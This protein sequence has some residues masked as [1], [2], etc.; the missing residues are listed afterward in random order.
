MLRRAATVFAAGGLVAGAVIAG[1]AVSSGAATQA[2]SG[3]NRN[4]VSVKSSAVR[5]ALHAAARHAT[6]PSVPAGSAGPIAKHDGVTISENGITRTNGPRPKS[7]GQVPSAANTAITGASGVAAST[8]GLDLYDQRTANNGNQFTEVPPDQGLCTGN[9]FVIEIVNSVIQ[10]FDASTLQRL[11]GVTDTN[12][13]LGYP[14]E[15][16][17][18]TGVYGPEPTDPSC[19]YAE[20]HFV[21]VVLTIEVRPSSGNLTGK[22]HLDFA[23]STTNDPRGGWNVYQLPV[24]DDGTQGTPSHPDCPCLGDYPHIGQDA[25]GVFVTTNEYPFPGGGP[26]LF[27]NNYNGAQLY[28]ISKAALISGASSVPVLHFEDLQA[29]G[30]PG[31]TMWP[32]QANPGRYA[33]AHNGTEYFAETTTAEEALGQGVAYN[34][35]LWSLTNTA[36]LN[37]SSPS[38]TLH[39]WSLPSKKYVQPP[40]SNQKPGN[41]PLG[42]CVATAPCAHDFLGMA[43][44]FGALRPGGVDSLDGRMQQT[45]YDNGK[46]WGEFGAAVSVNSRIRAG[47]EWLVID[48]ATPSIAAQGLIGNASNNL[49]MPSIA[50]LPGGNGVMSLTAVGDTMDPSSAF[51]RINA[52]GP[53][54]AVNV[55][56]WGASPTDDF[57]EYNAFDCANTS[58]PLATPRW[59]DY[60]AVVPVGNQLLVANEDIESSCTLAQWEADA[61]CNATRAPLGNWSTHISRVSP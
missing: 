33:T 40:Q 58:P 1:P 28:A 7:P 47:A 59:G 50:V 38:P 9:G 43:S 34:I 23:V 25:N 51:V 56:K 22:Y 57:C 4:A 44:D 39:A 36:S 18:T 32:A 8:Q 24:Q 29:G 26:G 14:P 17:R 37:S 60:G 21:V 41:T 10:V 16:N 31:F 52:S 48:T 6:F 42:D 13:F 20:G 19:I 3:A 49:V 15:I 2:K 35:L 55:A 12:T 11:T 5:Q 30:T 54:G 45:W 61:T 53:H 27:G 46:L